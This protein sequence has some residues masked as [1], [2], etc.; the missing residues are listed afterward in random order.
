MSDKKKSV[1]YEPGRIGPLVLKNRLI[2]SATFENAATTEGKVSDSLIAIH[3]LLAKGGA[4]LIITGISWFYPKVKAPPRMVRVDL[5]SFIPGLRSLSRAV[6][7]TDPDCRIILQLHHP[8]RQ[9]TNPEDL[10]R[11][12]LS[13]APGLVGIREKTPGSTSKRIGGTRSGRTGC[14]VRHPRQAL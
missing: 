10:S 12:N 14:P 2:R 5:D 11:I 9:V 1:V 6:H 4:G 7:E 13:R 3:K 8:G